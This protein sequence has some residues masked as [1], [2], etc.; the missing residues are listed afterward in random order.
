MPVFELT[1][2]N[3]AS[4]VT[5]T[6]Y[7]FADSEKTAKDNV[8]LN[9]WIVKSVKRLTE[10]EASELTLSYDGLD[11]NFTEGYNVDALAN[12]PNVDNKR[13]NNS[14]IN[15]NKT[16]YG[17]PLGLGG[18]NPYAID[19]VTN[20]EKSAVLANGNGGAA[21]V[22]P[23]ENLANGKTN[24]SIDDNLN[25]LP[26]SPELEYLLT[27]NFNFSAIE[28][29]LNEQL[30]Y[31]LKIMTN[32][33]NYIIFAHADDVPVGKDAP[34]KSNYALSYLRGEAV[35]KIMVINGIPADNIKVVGLGSKY[36]LENT[37]GSSLANRRAGIYGFRT[38]E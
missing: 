3:S 14:N 16:P 38:Q 25:L 20:P 15:Q 9:G 1:I 12:T 33:R 2:E 17:Y 13:K 19:H 30:S 11:N 4:K 5:T 34:Y 7:V 27:L 37:K 31:R 22:F 10:K 29:I 35:K 6:M 24:R 21:T 18:A 32:K 26:D 28:P 23:V 8:Y 36:P